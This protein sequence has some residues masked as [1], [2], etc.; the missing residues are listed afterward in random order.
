LEAVAPHFP[1]IDK[2]KRGDRTFSRKD[3]TGQ[4]LQE[5]EPIGASLHGASALAAM[6]MGT[7]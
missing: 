1:V 7:L 4:R 2:S 3:F 6:P 5:A